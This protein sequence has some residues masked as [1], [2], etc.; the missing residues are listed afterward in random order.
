MKT[1]DTLKSFKG[2]WRSLTP[3]QQQSL[4]ADANTTT[5]YINAHLVYARKIPRKGK[6]ESLWAACR[7]YGAQFEKHEL[8]AFFFD[9]VSSQEQDKQEGRNG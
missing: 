6:M 7:K 3:E 5:G 2:F 9:G 8:I 1:A 4:A